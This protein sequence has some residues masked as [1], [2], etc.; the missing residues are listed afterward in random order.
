MKLMTWERS[1]IFAELSLACLLAGCGGGSGNEAPKPP[2]PAAVSVAVSVSPSSAILDQGATRQFAAT[3]TGSANTAVTWSVQE[4][5]GGSVTSAG[6]YTAPTATGTFHVI[7]TSQADPTKTA[8]AVATV[9]PFVPPSVI[10]QP[11]SELLVGSGRRQF[12]ALTSAGEFNSLV[13]W[14]VLEPGGGTITTV[15][16]Y[17]AP[18]QLGTFHV[19]ATSTVNP[20]VQGTATISVVGSGFVA[21]HGNFDEQDELADLTTTLLADGRALILGGLIDCLSNVWTSDC[22]AP[23]TVLRSA[24]IYDS[25]TRT[26]SFTGSLATGRYAHTATLLQN[27]KVLVVGGFDSYCICS[28][29]VT[30]AEIFD[31]GTGAF[32]SAG[33]PQVPRAYHTA[34]LLADGTVLIV[35]GVQGVPDLAANG[36][37]PALAS[38]EIYDPVTNSFSSVGGMSNRRMNH[39]ATLLPSGMV[40]IVGGAPVSI[41]A[42]GTVGDA[43]AEL[44]DPVAHTFSPAGA[45]AT[46]RFGHTA[47][48][49]PTGKVLVAGGSAS[50]P[51]AP[52]FNGQNPTASVEIFDSQLSMWSTAGMMISPRAFHT[53]TLL[54][55]GQ[56]L[57]AGGGSNLASVADLFDPQSAASTQVG[58][59][60]ASWRYRHVATL[61][62]DGTVLVVGGNTGIIELYVQNVPPAN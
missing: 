41:G 37:V 31:P 47:T 40:L 38:A 14:S 11:A 46:P 50:G 21:I 56:V 19:V 4:P 7:A 62:P 51:T 16:L 49:L 24:Q 26:F 39:T 60:L 42:R 23:F 22:T 57:F 53:A 10:V 29:P 9:V 52:V 28:T 55:S 44:H 32:S 2:A 48:L 59:M 61:M 18:I 34:T 45:M 36:S 17:T 25:S 58:A 35:G 43:T 1:L 33:T 8:I 3:V 12:F 5:A 20:Q 30:T 6:V 13:T 54:P 27:G 15:G